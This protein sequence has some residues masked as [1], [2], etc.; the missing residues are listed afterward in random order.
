MREQWEI[1][2]LRLVQKRLRVE[3]EA[4]EKAAREAEDEWR[5]AYFRYLDAAGICRFC[6]KPL[7]E[8]D[9]SWNTPGHIVIG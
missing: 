4:K 6:E 5:T 8:G 1:T 2:K 9:H 7:N 3:Y